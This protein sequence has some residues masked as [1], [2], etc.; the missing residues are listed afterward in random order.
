MPTGDPGTTRGRPEEKRCS[1]F[2]NGLRSTVSTAAD[3]EADEIEEHLPGLG[4]I[5]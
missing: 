4:Y 3:T 2:R 1:V 5:E